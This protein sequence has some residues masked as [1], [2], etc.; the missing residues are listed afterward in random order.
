MVNVMMYLFLVVN[1]VYFLLPGNN[2][3]VC[4][5]SILHTPRNMLAV[6]LCYSYLQPFIQHLLYASIVT[7]Q[8][9]PNTKPIGVQNCL[10]RWHLLP[11]P[12]LQ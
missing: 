7:A 5:H 9:L 11:P 6:S 8:N 12:L 1:I 3:S 2:Q 4:L 10:M